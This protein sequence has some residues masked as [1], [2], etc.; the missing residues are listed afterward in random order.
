MVQRFV[1][2]LFLLLI[3]CINLAWSIDEDFEGTLKDSGLLSA[4]DTVLLS[5][6]TYFYEDKKGFSVLSGGKERVKAY[7]V[8]TQDALYVIDWSRRKKAYVTVHHE[9]YKDLSSVE[10]AGG[11]FAVRLVT[12]QRGSDKFN[13]YEIVD[14]RNALGTNPEKTREAKTII[15]AGIQGYDVE[16][17]AAANNPGP[18][19]I[20][21]QE[22]TLQTLEERIQRLEEL[23]AAT[24]IQDTKETGENVPACN[25]V[26]PPQNE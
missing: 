22:R 20:L 25:C 3:L 19:D 18:K 10:I 9:P 26:C 21:E 6:N 16:A 7:I 5:S 14:G 13:S 11:S 2:G 4:D 17:V 8:L 1:L 15:A 12:K 23:Q 24:A